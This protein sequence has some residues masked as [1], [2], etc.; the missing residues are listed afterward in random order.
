MSNRL[1]IV[2]DDATRDALTATANERGTRVATL[3]ATIL[4]THLG[5]G[6][7]PAPPPPAPPT[8]APAA[9]ET[10]PAAPPPRP[11]AAWLQ[12]DRGSEWR[13]QAWNQLHQL[14]TDY[15]DITDL[16]NG[17]WHHDRFTRDGLLALAVWRAELD[18]G[19]QP[20]PRAELQWLT[21][22]RDFR[23]TVDE[24]RRQHRNRDTPAERPTSW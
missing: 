3:A 11:R 6:C 7:Q 18:T 13:D 23:R 12:L 20:D 9:A 4:T 1:T 15:P 21:A 8:P 10:G 24:H 2:V 17:P 5:G 19:H 14:R 16:L 22:L